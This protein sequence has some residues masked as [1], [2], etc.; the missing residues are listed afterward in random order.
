VSDCTSATKCEYTCSTGFTLQDNACV[1]IPAP[2]PAAAGVYSTRITVTNAIPSGTFYTV[3][4]ILKDSNGV[5]LV[6]KSERM[7][8]IAAGGTYTAIAQYPFPARVAT[9][10][11]SVQDKLPHQGWTVHGQLNENV[12][13]PVP[14]A[15]SGTG[16][17]LLTTTS[18]R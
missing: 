18:S 7:E 17:T 3:Y 8:N 4:T 10:E 15:T 16:L 2:P 13:A 12:A 14:T 1:Q 6:F 9:K 5:I 11:V